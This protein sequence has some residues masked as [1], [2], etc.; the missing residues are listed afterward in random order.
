MRQNLEY[1]KAKQSLYKMLSKHRHS[2]A[3]CV[4][5]LSYSTMSKNRN[6]A[7]EIFPLS[8]PASGRKKVRIETPTRKSFLVMAG[9]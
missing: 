3:A 6:Y 9:I 1:A 2:A 8:G 7:P 4:F 5:L